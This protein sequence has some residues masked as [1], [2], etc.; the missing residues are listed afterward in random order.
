LKERM[1]EVTGREDGGIGRRGAS[2]PRRKLPPRQ[3]AG[4]EQLQEG[5]DF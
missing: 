4:A 3:G 1:H 5:V 2:R